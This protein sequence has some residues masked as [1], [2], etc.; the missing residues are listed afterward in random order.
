M[1]RSVASDVSALSSVVANG[2]Q[3]MQHVSSSLSKIPYGGFSPV[4][5]QTGSPRRPSRGPTGPRLYAAQVWPS[6]PV[7][8]PGNSAGRLS[9]HLP[10][11]GPWLAS[12]LC[13]PAGSS[14]TM[15][16][17]ETLVSSRRL[18]LYTAGL[19]GPTTSH[20]RPEVPQ[21]TLPVST[22]VPHSVPRQTVRL[23][24]TVTSPHILASAIFVVARHPLHPQNPGPCGVCNEAASFALCYGPLG[25]LALPRPGLLLSS[26]HPWWSPTRNVEYNYMG[27]QSIPMTGLAPARHAAL[28]AANE[29]TRTNTSLHLVSSWNFRGS[30]PFVAANRRA[31]N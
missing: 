3:T 4:R 7:A 26:F 24:V 16:S 31:M 14:L 12:G 22:H 2:H 5:L 29:I 23:L 25:L 1:C 17:S 6:N 21:F 15:A 8:I 30:F 20:G 10:S 9:P 18:M 13:C 28:W 19:C 11:R 27:T